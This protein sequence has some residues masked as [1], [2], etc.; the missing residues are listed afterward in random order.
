MPTLVAISANVTMPVP[1]VERRWTFL[2][3]RAAP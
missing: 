1:T 2:I 3:T